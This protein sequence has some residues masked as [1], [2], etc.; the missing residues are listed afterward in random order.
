MRR[1]GAQVL[2]VVQA[3]FSHAA[4]IMDYDGSGADVG[5]DVLEAQ[6]D[7]ALLDRVLNNN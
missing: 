2:K 7:R 6:L 5:P 1:R 3:R 4:M